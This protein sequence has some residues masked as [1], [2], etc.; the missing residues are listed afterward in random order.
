MVP[1]F[2]YIQLAFSFI[3]NVFM[4]VLD[5]MAFLDIMT[6]LNV[7]FMCGFLLAL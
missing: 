3:L 2:S 1:I 5:I 7:L 4:A 6:F